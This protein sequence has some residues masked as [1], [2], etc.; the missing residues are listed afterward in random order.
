[1]N[2]SRS[3]STPALPAGSTCAA[4]GLFNGMHLGHKAVIDKMLELSRECGL[5]PLVFTFT[6]ANNIPAAKGK[7]TLLLSPQSMNSMLEQSGV[8]EVICP[9]FDEFR[10]LEPGQFVHDILG[11]RLGVARVV[12][13]YDF[14]FG[15]NAA[16]DTQSL[17]KLCA[18]SGIA[19]DVVP[20]V[21]ADGQPAAT[22]RI[23]AFIEEGNIPAANRLFGR[24]FTIDFEVVAGRQI[25]R[26]LDWPTINQAFPPGYTL[27]RFGVYA[28]ITNVHG[29]L[30]SSVTNVGVKPT[31]GGGDV[32]A[33]TYI[34]GFSGDIYGEHIQVQFLKFLRPERKFDGLQALKEAIGA[35]AQQAD[36]IASP[37]LKGHSTAVD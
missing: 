36:K 21:I 27:P 11:A 8:R 19:V 3:L 28:T 18:Q 5:T 15:K 10:S 9:D 14:H 35:D 20:A 1:M 33:E 31:V 26:T 37:L 4:I 30:Y 24:P 25:G 13:G 6:A 32:L 22:R 29:R 2:I 16:G 17:R 7:M 12:C 34:Q 23:R